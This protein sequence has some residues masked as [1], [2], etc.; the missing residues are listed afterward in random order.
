MRRSKPVEE[1]SG[2]VCSG[3][4]AWHNRMPG[5]RPNLHV[6]GKCTFPTSGY[7][8]E[9]KRKE[10]QGINPTNLLLE[11]TVR[12]P[13][14]PVSEV[15]TEVEV[16]YQEETEAF[17]ADVTILPDGVTVPVKQISLAATRSTTVSLD[18]FIEVTTRA[19]ARALA[20]QEGGQLVELNPQPLPPGG[21]AALNLP[22]VLT[23]RPVRVVDRRI[24]VGIIAE[25]ILREQL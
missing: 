20:A 7:T 8:V 22:D 18:D 10:P 4:S 1:G 14:G 23:G 5:S 21:I 11:R 19:V 9:L 16:H 12:K 3:W 2:G 17:Y 24:T 6:L 15:I 25:P 13:T